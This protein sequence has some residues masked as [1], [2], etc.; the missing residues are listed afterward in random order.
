L[1]VA[2]GPMAVTDSRACTDAPAERGVVLPPFTSVP[3]QKHVK[4]NP[5]CVPFGDLTAVVA[6]SE[7][8]GLF[9]IVRIEHKG[10]VYYLT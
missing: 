7:S 2:T 8:A 1:P 9:Y 4:N 6:E 10:T 3:P 5:C